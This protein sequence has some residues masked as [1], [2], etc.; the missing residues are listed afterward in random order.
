MSAEVVAMTPQSAQS[1]TQTPPGLPRS[2]DYPEVPVGAVL[3]GAARRWPAR[4]GWIDET[5]PEGARELTFSAALRRAS[6]F[7]HALRARGIGVG[8]VVAVHAPNCIDYP[9]VYYGIL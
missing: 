1:A 6:Q 9:V 4:V 2:L 5:A 8:D 3:R 7:A